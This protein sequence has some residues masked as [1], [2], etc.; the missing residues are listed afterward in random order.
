[1]RGR[2]LVNAAVARINYHA[3]GQPGFLD[4]DEAFAPIAQDTLRIAPEGGTVTASPTN[5]DQHAVTL[6]QGRIGEFAVRNRS[7]QLPG[8][9]PVLAIGK[10]KLQLGVAAGLAL[11]RSPTGAPRSG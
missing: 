1:M 6:V 10:V 4:R 8:R 2:V 7:P 11:R 5:G 9:L 3:I